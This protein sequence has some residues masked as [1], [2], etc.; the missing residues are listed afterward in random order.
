MSEQTTQHAFE[1]E[2]FFGLREQRDN[3]AKVAVAA[4]A[5]SVL[6]LLSLLALLPLKETKPY[7]VIVDKTTG[8]AEKIVQ[9]RPASLQQQEA[10]L[11]AELVSY[12]IDRETYDPAD[13]RVRIPDVMARS[14]GNAVQS[15][16]QIWSAGSAQYPP[17][18]YGNDVR[19]RVVV[20]SVS[21]TPSGGRD[22]EDLARVRI[23]KYREEK[24]RAAV[25]RSFVATV[26]YQFKPQENATLESVWKNPLGF[27]VMA[28]R[29]DAETAE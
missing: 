23:T 28:Y 15:L 5:A 12:V 7:V 13:N 9:I 14:S 21:L 29:I 1:D 10:V 26:G 27:D 3:W 8:E 16:T 18:I 11:Q 22:T 25:Q 4:A 24:G 17:T 20:K 2:L 19:V 6:S